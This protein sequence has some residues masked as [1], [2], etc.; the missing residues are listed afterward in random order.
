MSKIIR[1]FILCFIVVLMFAGCVNKSQGQMRLDRMQNEVLPT[2]PAWENKYGADAESNLYCNLAINAAFMRQQRRLNDYVLAEI[3]GL[4][5]RVDPN[6]L[7]QVQVDVSG[8]D[9]NE[10][11]K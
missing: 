6:T 2:H 11:G 10:P 9:V 4:N 3:K 8:M 7:P 5:K 1:V